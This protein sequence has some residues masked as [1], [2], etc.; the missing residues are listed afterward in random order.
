MG[1]KIIIESETFKY[2]T[3]DERI[4][5][6]KLIPKIDRFDVEFK[7]ALNGILKETSYET[8]I[9]QEDIYWWCNCLNNRLGSMTETFI[10]LQ[11]HY[12]REQEKGNGEPPNESADKLLLNYY[13]EIFYYYF[14]SAR[15]VLGQ[16]LNISS[17]LKIEK[18]IILNDVF[19]EKIKSKEIKNALTDF[20]KNTN[21][22]YNI[23]NSFTHRFT[24]THQDFRAKKSVIKEDNK[25]SF[26]SVQEIRI[27]TFIDDIENLMKHFGCLMN[28]I[29]KEIK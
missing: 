10:Y 17:D 3:K 9:R 4:K 1:T 8:A 15:D 21:D 5:I 12:L 18:R 2:P 6:N 7:S 19:V 16:L 22:S 25:I 20:L 11:T 29:I 26:H 28:K 14:F 24:P 27:E 13:I 23:R